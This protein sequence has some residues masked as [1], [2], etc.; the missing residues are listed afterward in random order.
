M[1]MKKH[2]AAG[3]PDVRIDITITLSRRPRWLLT[4]IAL[5]SLHLPDLA[6][7]LTG[8]VLRAVGGS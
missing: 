8:L 3:P 5:G 7:R 4:G 6:V 1:A 2:D